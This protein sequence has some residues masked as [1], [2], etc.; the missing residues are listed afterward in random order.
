MGVVLEAALLTTE[1]ALLATDDALLAALEVE[2]EDE[3][4]DEL[5]DELEAAELAA[6]ELDELLPP[7][8]SAGQLRM[9]SFTNAPEAVS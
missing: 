5:K 6:L 7:A 1:D 2:I 3:L 8:D 9:A 4:K